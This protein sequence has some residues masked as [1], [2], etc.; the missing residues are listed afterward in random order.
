MAEGLSTV[1]GEQDRKQAPGS[2]ADCSDAAK[3]QD[4]TWL[5]FAAPRMEREGRAVLFK[6]TRT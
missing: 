6:A 1:Q 2:L 3:C 4:V 5:S